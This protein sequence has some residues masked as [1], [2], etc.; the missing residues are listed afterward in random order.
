MAEIGPD[1]KGNVRIKSADITQN[2]GRD[3]AKFI[4][5]VEALELPISFSPVYKKNPKTNTLELEGVV[6][7]VVDDRYFFTKKDWEKF[8]KFVFK[9]LVKK[10]KQHEEGREECCC[11]YL[12]EL[13]EKVRE[14]L[15]RISEILEKTAEEL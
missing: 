3:L 14:S 12:Y 11:G 13:L 2:E 5:S 1:S 7:E 15:K 10:W 9:M 4:G 8:W 6:V